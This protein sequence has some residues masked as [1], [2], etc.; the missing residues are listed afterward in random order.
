MRRFWLLQLAFVLAACATTSATTPTALPTVVSDHQLDPVEETSTPIGEPTAVPT[1]APIS[2]V[3]PDDPAVWPSTT[4]SPTATAIVSQTTTITSTAPAASVPLLQPQDQAPALLPEFQSDLDKAERWN[5]YKIEAVIDPRNSTIAGN[6]LLTYTNR[7]SVPLE[8]LYFHLY[9][10]LPDFGGQ[11]TIVAVEVD[12]QAV[13]VVY[14]QRRYLL[15]VDLPKPLRPGATTTLSLAF[16]TKAPSNASERNYGAFNRENGVFALASCYPIVA[17]VRDGKWDIAWPDSKGDFVNSETALYEARLTIPLGWTLAAT[18]V[19]VD[20]HT[21]GSRQDFRVVSGPQRDFMVSVVQLEKISAEVDGTTINSYYQSG[22]ARG[23]QIALQSAVD[24]VRA[25]NKRYGRYPL[26]ELDIVQLAASTFLGVEYPGIIFINQDL[27]NRPKPLEIT[28]AHE[29][30]HQWWYS[31][32]GNDVQ[33]EAWL[34]EALASYSQIVYQEEVYGAEAAEE[35]LEGFRQRYRTN[36]AA[37]RDA[38]VAQPNTA[39]GRNY[40]ALVYGKAV[41]FFQVLRNRMGDEA[42]DRFLHDYYASSRYA[43]VTGAH[44]LAHAEQACSC[45]LDELYHDWITTAVPVELP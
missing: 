14:E 7:D 35:E 17:I 28:V 32:V 10:N 33:T 2:P 43:Y 19:I 24:S 30:G 40:V 36:L 21:E 23:G 3:P 37:G 11:L 45:E 26:V 5:R 4:V 12:G 39:F 22:S 29:V 16:S 1:T 25:F 8:Q 42:F 6:E 44:L 15:R 9:P 34:D 31:I 38:P 27:Y 13:P 20:T 41:L 18:G